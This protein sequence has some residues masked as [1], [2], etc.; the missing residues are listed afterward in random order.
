MDWAVRHR[1][2]TLVIGDPRGVLDND[3]GTVHNK[4]TRDWAPGQLISVL[5]DK[6]RAAG[7]R[8]LIVNERGTSSTCPNPECARRVPRPAGRNFRCPHCGLDG[9]RDLAGAANIAARGSG[10]GNPP[11]LPDERGTTHRRAGRHLPGVRPERRD[12]RRRP[13]PRRPRRRGHLA[14]SGPPRTPPHGGGG[15]SLAV[16]ARSTSDPC[17]P[18]GTH[19]LLH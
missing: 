7:I 8:V 10:G 6:A 17:N 14:G 4:R 2:G 1:A 9:H 13:S 3:A 11:P 16:T 5:S 19:E 15:E 12:P 18:A